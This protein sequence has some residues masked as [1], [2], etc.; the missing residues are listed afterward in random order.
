MALPSLAELNTSFLKK[1]VMVSTEFVSMQGTNHPPLELPPLLFFFSRPVTSS[2][3]LQRVRN[4][5]LLSA[6]CGIHQKNLMVFQIY[7]SRNLR[8]TCRKYS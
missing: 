2:I 6:S 5:A 8:N 1:T 7:T 4:K 3:R